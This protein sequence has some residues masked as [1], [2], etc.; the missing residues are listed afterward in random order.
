MEPQHHPIVACEL[1]LRL[2]IFDPCNYMV[3]Y[4]MVGEDGTRVAR[5]GTSL[6]HLIHW[7][8][9][10]DPVSKHERSK[11][12]FL[13]LHDCITT[14]SVIF[15]ACHPNFF[16]HCSTHTTALSIY[17]SWFID[18][19]IHFC[20]FITRLGK[21]T[22]MPNLMQNWI[23]NLEIISMSGLEWSLN[24]CMCPFNL[25]LPYVSSLRQG[26]TLLTW[27]FHVSNLHQVVLEH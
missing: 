13:F 10:T 5:R 20:P 19:P 7:H 16:C 23:P 27:D 24:V 15:A 21:Q 18:N 25:S 11:K 4:M 3:D 6:Y 14:I 8:I 22:N 26:N 1:A 12:L 9:D 2:V 17:C